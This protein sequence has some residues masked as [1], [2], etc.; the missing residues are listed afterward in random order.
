MV[1]FRTDIIPS[2]ANASKVI[3]DFPR[4]FYDAS[5]LY[6]VYGPSQLSSHLVQFVHV[7]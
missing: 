4:T 6:E 7:L 5:I 3:W 1:F 2:I